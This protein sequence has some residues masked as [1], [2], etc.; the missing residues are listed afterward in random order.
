MTCLTCKHHWSDVNNPQDRKM[1][2]LGWK[3]CNRSDDKLK[4]GRYL[5]VN[6]Q[7]CIKYEL[8]VLQK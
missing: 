3:L 7:A 8:N 5:H 1:A 4:N 6:A 2:E